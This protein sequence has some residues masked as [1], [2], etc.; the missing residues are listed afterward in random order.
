VLA[1]SGLMFAVAGVV[2]L[3]GIITAEAMYPATYTTFDNEISDLGATRPPNS[4]IR[5]P[6]AGIFNTTMVVAG[7]AMLA[8]VPGLLA[9]FERRR[10]GIWML[11]VGIG[12][13]GVGIFPGNRA[14]FHGIFALLAFVAGG[15][16]A[17]VSAS[18]TRG[19][20]RLLAAGL[21]GIAL[22]SL[23]VAMLG[24]LTPAMDELGD[25]G[26]E[27]WVAYPT[28]LWLVLFGGYLLNQPAAERD[29]SSEG[30]LP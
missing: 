21:G 28:I 29:G 19:L 20:F 14:P 8:G 15:G 11:L 16:A 13:L 25:G 12:V 24:D 9:G 22:A 1:V 6:S 3:M 2:L 10:M 5:Q 7:L 27:R 30:G 26:V 18:V 17:I 4:V 23:A